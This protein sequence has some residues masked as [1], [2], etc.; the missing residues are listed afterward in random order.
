MK[1]STVKIALTSAL[2]GLVLAFTPG[3]ASAQTLASLSSTPPTP[4]A[5][6]ISQFSFAGNATKPD[7]LNYYADN[8]A[9]AG[10]GAGQ[11]FT[12]LGN[13]TGYVLTSVA[14]KS[15]AL[16]SG[17]T[18][19]G[20][21]AGGYIL[22]IY[23]IAN[24][25]NA[26]QLASYTL[27][28]GTFSFIPGDWLQVT[29]LGIP[30]SPAT[31]YAY[32]FQRSTS[33]QG[34]DNLDVASGNPYAGGEI[35]LIPNAGGTITTGASHGFD[36]QFDV[37]LSLAGSSPVVSTP[38]ATP[39]PCYALSPVVLTATAT[40]ANYQWQTNTDLTGGL[41][42]SWV[43]IP[44]ATNLTITNIPPDAFPGGSDYL[45]DYRLIATATLSTTSAPVAL[46]VASATSPTVSAN[47]SPAGPISTRVGAT[48]NFTAS[49]VGTQPI[50]NQWQTDAGQTGTFTNIPGATTGTLTITNLQTYNAGN[51]RLLASNVEGST[52]S[53]SANVQVFNVIWSENFNLPTSAD[54]SI[55]HVGWVDDINSSSG[56]TRI[57]ASSGNG[58]TYPNMAVYSYCPGLDNEAFYAT[59][60][61]ANGGPYFGGT[62]TNHQALPIINLATVQNLT[63]AADLNSPYAGTST[64]SYI[65]VQLNFGQWYVSATELLPQPTTTAFISDSTTFNPSASAWNLLT[66]SG[67]GSV[68][69]TNLPAIGAAASAPL[70]G[71]ITGAGIVVV[72]TAG[73]T[74]QFDNYAILGN[75][76]FTAL[77]VISSPPFS[78]TNYTGTTATF[79]VTATTNGSTVGLTY[80]WQTNT[81][82]GSSTWGNL[83][84]AGQFSGVTSDT[85]KIANVSAAANHRDYRVIVTDG[86]GSTTSTPPATLYL[87]DS[88]PLLTSGT[89]I[90]PNASPLFGT[91]NASYRVG[92]HNTVN[93]SASFIGD[94][95]ISYQW[96]ISPN[97][98][99]SAAVNIP[100]ATNSI[101]TLSNPQT[102]STGYYTLTV[103]NSQS[104]T[105]TNSGLAQ[106]TVLPADPT[107]IQWSAPVAINGLTAAQFLYGVPGTFIGAESIVAPTA[108]TVTNGGNTFLFDN[109]NLSTSPASFTGQFRQELNSYTGPSTGDT[110][111][112]TVLGVGQENS[113]GS[114]I[115]AQNLV[116]GQLYSAQL[117]A[118]NDT[119][120]NTRPSYWS[121]PLDASNADVSATFLM[122]DNVYV[123]ATFV[124]N[125]TTETFVQNETIGGYASCVLIRN[126][127]PTLT[128]SKSGSSLQLN[129]NFGTLLE[130]TNIKG[131]WTSDG[132]AGSLTVTPTGPQ[133]FYRVSFP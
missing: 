43:N 93:I 133:K 66:V 28:A 120:G 47:I 80:Q 97:A 41:G 102:N 55:T 16:D 32:T 37:G 119:A 74:L 111:L 83:S 126:G 44:G 49:F 101:L 78:Q 130:A 23:S 57:F 56:D 5:N 115:V 99:G 107:L 81:A 132:T 15:G 96:S 65:A 29:G 67:T 31:T 82:V 85:L 60:A 52:T 6:D 72:H 22:D 77:P 45:L 92:N 109:G 53:S 21:Q 58:V 50:T 94:L 131:P 39:N 2:T 59:T 116:V 34:W 95:P 3:T 68:N 38:T 27:G 10:N 42:G 84:N 7:G 30:L 110:N 128:E 90:Y 127:L 4:G 20:I 9:T 89:V 76:P 54:Q 125:N 8:G 108:I 33:G 36:A 1:T 122:G 105:P 129:W 51:Y 91:A 46:D 35:A 106:L 62:I 123:V 40:T 113:N 64:H 18:G 112:D 86:A 26:T 118:L 69:N 61:T 104:V 100:G 98:D 12:T 79:N 19:T 87:I 24:G 25:T 70:S 17:G 88:A 14:F 48:L 71:Y 114:T 75:I 121:D 103:S 13:P 11:T 73:S 63:F 124:A 117:V